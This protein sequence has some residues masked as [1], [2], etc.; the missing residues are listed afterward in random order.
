MTTNES[1]KQRITRHDKNAGIKEAQPLN[2]TTSADPH[3]G[4][5]NAFYQESESKIDHVSK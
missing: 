1:S 5:M 2:R 4:F 3:S